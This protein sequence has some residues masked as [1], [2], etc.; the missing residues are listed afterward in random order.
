MGVVWRRYRQNLTKNPKERVYSILKFSLDDAFVRLHTNTLCD[1]GKVIK[2]KET[3]EQAA[4]SLGF[5]YQGTLSRSYF[6][7][8][9]FW[10]NGANFVE[11]NKHANGQKASDKRPICY[12][13]SNGKSLKT[14]TFEY[15]EWD[16]II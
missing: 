3:C 14:L 9:C 5:K 2:D 15:C 6:P 16:M 10:A 12:K 11:F 1:G 13:D 7:S 4:K 8:G